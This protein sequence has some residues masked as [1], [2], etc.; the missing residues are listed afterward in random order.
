MLAR[1]E[2]YLQT[3]ECR[4]RMMMVGHV[5]HS[6]TN[7][8]KPPK[9]GEAH[10]RHRLTIVCM[11]YTSD[12]G[13]PMCGGKRLCGKAK[14]PISW[15]LYRPKVMGQETPDISNHCLH[16]KVYAGNPHSMTAH[17]CAKSILDVGWAM[18]RLLLRWADH[19]WHWLS[20]VCR[21]SVMWEDQAQWL[22]SD[23][24]MQWP[25]REVYARR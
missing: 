18:L 24:Y 15:L 19:V 6:L 3:Y 17:K 22:L 1:H 5:L 2:K 16:E 21:P 25:K 4:L 14:P 11:Q 10:I 13:Y 20:V 7:V 9:I 23:V 12:V 8:F